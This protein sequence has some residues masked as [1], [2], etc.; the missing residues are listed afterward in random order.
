M[1][2]C[3]ICRDRPGTTIDHVIPKSK[4]GKNHHDNIRM[5]CL[6]C[7]ETKGDK[8]LLTDDDFLDVQIRADKLIR[9]WKRNKD[10]REEVYIWQAMRRKKFPRSLRR[11]IPACAKVSSIY[12]PAGHNG[13]QP[14]IKDENGR[15]V[16]YEEVV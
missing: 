14:A 12:L 6:A 16:G 10:W 13:L 5:A 1:L 2:P 9:G 11:R 4:G 15:I 3:W 8:I 7:N